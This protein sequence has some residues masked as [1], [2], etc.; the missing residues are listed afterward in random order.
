MYACTTKRIIAVRF[1]HI[2]FAV[3][4]DSLNVNGRQRS[5]SESV[6]II[7]SPIYGYNIGNTIIFEERISSNHYYYYYYW[8]FRRDVDTRANLCEYVTRI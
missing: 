8:P 2:I 6:C 1:D 4:V 3:T 7:I 5:Q